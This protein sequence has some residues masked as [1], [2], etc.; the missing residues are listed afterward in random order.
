MLVYKS[1]EC[2]AIYSPSYGIATCRPCLVC[3]YNPSFLTKCSKLTSIEKKKPKRFFSMNKATEEKRVWEKNNNNKN[4]HKIMVGKHSV[5]KKEHIHFCDETEFLMV[6]LLRKEGRWWI[7]RNWFSFF[8][9]YAVLWWRKCCWFDGLIC[10]KG[11][12]YGL[13]DDG[14]LNSY[15]ISLQCIFI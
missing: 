2:C 12:W 3:R 4:I 14:C 13:T 15:S 1:T 11:K 9:H 5:V 8:L 6:L 7:R 10:K